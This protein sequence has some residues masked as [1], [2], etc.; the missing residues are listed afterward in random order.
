L[1]AY[2]SLKA[3]P[4]SDI[5]AEEAMI[6]IGKWLRVASL[7]GRNIEAR[8]EMMLAALFGGV[9]LANAGVTACHALAYP[10][11]GMFG[12]P[13]GIANALLIPHV[14]R[15]NAMAS[16]ERFVNAAAFLGY[17]QEEGEPEHVAAMFCPEA[18]SELA[19]DLGL[20]ETLEDLD[21]GITEKHFEEMA[22][23]AMGVARPMENNPRVLT[24]EDCVRIYREAME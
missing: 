15:W 5:F 19:D 17:P 16:P 13:H 8:G 18:L 7:N 20:P 23:K 14:A 12:V 3:S 9:A 21:V 22:T 4:F 11:G 24:K 6:R 10:L 2:T 1:E